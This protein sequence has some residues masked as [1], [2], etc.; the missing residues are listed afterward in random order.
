M[1]TRNGSQPASYDLLFVRLVKVGGFILGMHEGFT[2]RDAAT[3]AL[4][5]FMLAGA[6]GA[7]NVIVRRREKP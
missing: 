4:A 7:E 1:A 2:T 5:S 6:Q 3:I